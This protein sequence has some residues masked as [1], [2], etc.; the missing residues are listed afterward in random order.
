MDD[1]LCRELLDNLHIEQTRKTNLTEIKNKL[2]SVNSSSISNSFLKS[3]ELLN[4]LEDSNSEQALL[5]CDILSLC[6]G[7]LSLDESSEVK[8][9]I[10]KSLSHSNPSVQAFGLR[11]LRRILVSPPDLFL[12]ETLILLTIKCLASEET[13]VGTASID[14]LVRMLPKFVHL[15]SVQENLD[16]L[17]GK[18]DIIRCRLYEV[19]VKLGQQS[20]VLLDSV[21]KYL[22]R[23]L[24]DLDEDDILLQ[25]NVLQ[26]LSELS[27]KSHGMAYLENNGVLDKVMKKTE[28]L[29]Q[30]PLASLLIPG[31]MRFY[32]SIAASQPVKIYDCYPKVIGMLFDCLLSED[33]TILPTAYDTLGCIAFSSEG[34]RQIHYKYGALLKKTLKHFN[35]VIK[36]LPNDLKLRLL[37]CLQVLFSVESSTADN[38]ISTITQTWYCDFAE[39]ENL[40]LVM[41]FIRNPFPDMKRAALALLKAIITHRWGQVYLLNTGGFIEYLLARQQEADKDVILDKY[42]IIRQLA[43]STVFSGQIMS[44]LKKYVSEGAFYLQGITEVVF[45]G[46]S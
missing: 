22:Q 7:N 17:L 6:M 29:E 37:S 27:T 5:V 33:L 3:P 21:E 14:I 39:E 41:D 35:A 4:C 26:V 45:E 30:N 36:N 28:S 32:G 8:S 19:A 34:K 2:I 23:A 38:Q 40:N 46:A 43:S 25:L 11:E 20:E 24:H 31:F 44:D 1:N 16:V 9:V 18:N 12:T 15:R 42:E 10:E 13:S